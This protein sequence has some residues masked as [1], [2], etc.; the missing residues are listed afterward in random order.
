MAAKKAKR[1]KKKAASGK[2]VPARKLAMGRK[3]AAGS[4]KHVAKELVLGPLER[5]GEA[6]V[7][8]ARR[9]WLSAESLVTSQVTSLRRSARK[10]RAKVSH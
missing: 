8:A 5:A 1:R 7:D 3:R 9:L 10:A 6:T 2:K 4:K